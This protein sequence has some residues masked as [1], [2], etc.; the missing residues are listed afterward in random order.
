MISKKRLSILF[1]GLYLLGMII[2]VFTLLN[3]KD[4]LIYDFNVLA[5]SDAEIADPAFIRLYT[6]IGFSLIL[7]LLATYFSFKADENNVIY[8]EKEAEDENKKDQ[9]SDA[10]G[11]DEKINIE[12]LNHFIKAKKVIQPADFDR[13]LSTICKQLEASQGAFYLAEAKSNK[14]IVRLKSSYAMSIGENEDIT[15]EFGEGLIGQVAEEQK[16]RYLDDIPGGFVQI[17]SGLGQA[18]PKY[19]LILPVVADD[20]MKGVVEIAGF[21]P[22]KDKD[23]STLEEFLTTLGKFLDN[24]AAHKDEQVMVEAE[25]VTG[26]QRTKKKKPE[27]K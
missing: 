5:I 7:G 19:L 26:T 23:I 2:S 15:F 18:S 6:V 16:S 8:I 14:N 21:V 1:I 22:F 3:F 9:V 25:V 10:T 13:L 11:E 4:N 17:I 27:G 20:Q 12:E 24:Q